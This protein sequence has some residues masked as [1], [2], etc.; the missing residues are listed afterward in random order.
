MSEGQ[1]L[2]ISLHPEISAI[3]PDG[4]VRMLVAKIWPNMD[5][6]VLASM[7]RAGMTLIPAG[8][9][10]V[11]FQLEGLADP[12]GAP[13]VE[14]SAKFLNIEQLAQLLEQQVNLW[15]PAIKAFVKIENQQDEDF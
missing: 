12:D 15:L 9:L 5:V 11:D 13:N 8:H 10:L 1:E 6:K 3:Q 2:T 7:F 14:Q 4:S